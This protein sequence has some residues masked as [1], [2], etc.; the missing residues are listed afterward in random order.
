[1]LPHPQPSAKVDPALLVGAITHGSLNNGAEEWHAALTPPPPA[2]HRNSWISTC[3]GQHRSVFLLCLVTLGPRSF[4]AQW[5]HTRE[6]NH[7]T[8]NGSL[9]LSETDD[10]QWPWVFTCHFPCQK[11]KYKGPHEGHFLRE[12]V[13][14]HTKSASCHVPINLI[15][16]F[17]NGNLWLPG[18]D[19]L[20]ALLWVV[21]I[22]SKT[23]TT[24]S[25][26][27]PRF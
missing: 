1:M 19:L 17:K 22:S 13:D 8:R 10:G 3:V 5:I 27:K 24:H 9:I 15:Y 18:S 2:P 16:P 21:C 23:V 7:R 25:P 4:L 6:K 20:L 11:S 12:I 26:F 14:L